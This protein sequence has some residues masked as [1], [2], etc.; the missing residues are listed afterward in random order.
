M[1]LPAVVAFVA[2]GVAMKKPAARTVSRLVGDVQAP[3]G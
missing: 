2:I 3:V 1:W